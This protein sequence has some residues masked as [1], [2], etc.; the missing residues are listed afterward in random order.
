MNTCLCVYAS[1]HLDVCICVK[2]GVSIR[3]HMHAQEQAE[4]YT[5]P[6]NIFRQAYQS[7]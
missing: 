7:P 1:L 3:T 5:C 6:G 4:I 2:T